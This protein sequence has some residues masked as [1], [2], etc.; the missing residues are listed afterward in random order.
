MNF[1]FRKPTFG[2]D[3]SEFA[4]APSCLSRQGL[5]R[6]H[7]MLAEAKAVLPHIPGPGECLHGIMTGRYDLMHLLLAIL[8]T[9][10]ARCEHMSIATLSFNAANVAEMVRLLDT[11]RVER[12][13]LLCS[14]FFHENTASVYKLCQD[15]FATRN[16]RLAHARNHC[17][18]VAMA[19]ADG[20]RLV[21]EGSANLRTNSNEEQFLLANDP[22]L[23]DWHARWIDAKISAHEI[24]TSNDS[25]TR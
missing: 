8:E 23:H 19:F 20:A 1:A 22:E 25:A 4:D 9:R 7:E 15:E 2:Q 18:V 5:I 3:R 16:G 21:L 10:E 11:G 14:K 13:S 17:K 6:R 12:L 24:N